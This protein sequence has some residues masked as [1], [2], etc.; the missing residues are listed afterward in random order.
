MIHKQYDKKLNDKIS[1]NYHI[2]I[3]AIAL[4]LGIKKMTDVY[5]TSPPPQPKFANANLGK[6]FLGTE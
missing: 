2:T 6:R 4:I 1:E 5:Q 3:H